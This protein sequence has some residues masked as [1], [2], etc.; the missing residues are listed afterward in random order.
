MKKINKVF[1]KIMEDKELSDEMEKVSPGI[2]GAMAGL[3]MRSWLPFGVLRKVIMGLIILGALIGA[4]FD[5]RWFLMLLVACTF[6]P[7]IMGEFLGALGIV[8]R[9]LFGTSKK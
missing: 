8:L 4:I 1:K 6:S 2:K 7:R 5:K 9:F 3:M